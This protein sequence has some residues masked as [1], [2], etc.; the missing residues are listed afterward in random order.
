M[1]TL[2]TATATQ[3]PSTCTA[4]TKV[5]VGTERWTAIAIPAITIP[6]IIIPDTIDD[7]VQLTILG[8]FT[9]YFYVI[10]FL[11]D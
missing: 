6:T 3:L 9:L 4:R 8:S 7:S 11:R 2:T 10:N 5:M 1:G